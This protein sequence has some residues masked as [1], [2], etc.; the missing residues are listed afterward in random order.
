[1]RGTCSAGFRLTG[2]GGAEQVLPL[3]YQAILA[4]SMVPIAHLTWSAVW[5]GVAA[6]AVE[7]RAAFMRNAAPQERRP[8]A[9][10]RGASHPRDRVSCS[11]LRG[12]IVVANCSDLRPRPTP[13]LNSKRSISR[14][15]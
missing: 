4:Q 3:P 13:A 6:G 8:I 12:M 7:R 9:A 15:R 14:R 11:M 5:S 10:R 2:T 1:M